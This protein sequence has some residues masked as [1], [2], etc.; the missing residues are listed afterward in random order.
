MD[1][2]P[3]GECDRRA[4]AD[5][6]ADMVAPDLGLQFVGHGE[7]HQIA[8]RGGFGDAHDLQ[9]LGLGLLGAG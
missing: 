7:H 6:V 8:P 3:V 5:V 1:V 2:Q 9:P 4:L